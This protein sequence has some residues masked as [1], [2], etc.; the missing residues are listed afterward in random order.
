MLRPPAHQAP[1]QA[2]AQLPQRATVPSG[3][4]TGPG[5]RRAPT[6]PGP[7]S[8]STL[9]T[10][11]SP[12]SQGRA[13]FGGC[14]DPTDSHGLRTLGDSRP[15]PKAASSPG[16]FPG[17]WRA[18]GGPSWGSQD[19]GGLRPVTIWEQRGAPTR[20]GPGE[21]VRLSLQRP[22]EEGD[23]HFTD[24]GPRPVK[25]PLSA[26]AVHS[27][28]DRG[29]SH[30]GPEPL[31]NPA[32]HPG[33]PAPPCIRCQAPASPQ[34]THV[35]S[36]PSWLSKADPELSAKARPAQDPGHSWRQDLSPSA[37]SVC[38]GPPARLPTTRGSTGVAVPS[39]PPLVAWGPDL[40]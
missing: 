37:Q 23:P 4:P 39:W 7:A 33:G 20:A 14:R 40:G 34:V 11:S 24:L 35:Y 26:Q 3:Q 8:C 30:R 36:T 22:W 15:C 19:W 18:A 29:V 10:L 27:W 12:P 13:Q 1:T 32:S 21:K 5:H 31:A 2:G 16:C 38:P 25:W 17:G 9:N 6:Q 28:E